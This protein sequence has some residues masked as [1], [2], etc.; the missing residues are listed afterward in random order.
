MSLLE[1]WKRF[2]F[3]CSVYAVVDVLSEPVTLGKDPRDEAM[4]PV[5][6]ACTT[7]SFP[8]PTGWVGSIFP[9]RGRREGVPFTLPATSPGVRSGPVE[10][11]AA[12]S[13]RVAPSFNR[14]Y[15]GRI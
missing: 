3:S 14:A 11:A 4:V 10:H 12:R 9:C 13:A 6:G 5:P 15:L 1:F 7:Q 2:V 8:L